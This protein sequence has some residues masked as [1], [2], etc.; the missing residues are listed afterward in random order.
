MSA[1]HSMGRTRAGDADG[2]VDDERQ[3]V[4]VGDGGERSMSTMSSL[5]LP[6]VRCRWRGSCQLMA[7]RRPSKS[8]ASAKRTVMPRL[9]QGV[10]EEVVGA[11]VE[12]G[13]GDDLVA[14]VGEGGDGE[15]LRGLAGGG[16]KGG[17]SA[18][19]RGDALL[20]DVGGGV[21]DAGVDVAELLQAE[22]AAGVVG[23]VEDGRRWSGRWARR[24]SWWRGRATWPAWTALVAKRSCFG[25]DMIFSSIPSWQFPVCE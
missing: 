9:G 16:G 17:R 13:G 23:V 8:S 10:V 20:E 25:S 12:R 18:F 6:R 15:R 22:E 11:A 14:G 5:G 19:E 3:A 7:A 2:V 24:A 21:H 4:F 1:P